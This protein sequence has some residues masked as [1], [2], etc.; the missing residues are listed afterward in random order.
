[1]SEKRWRIEFSRQAKE[2]LSKLRDKK[3]IARI[4]KVISALAINPRP[5][6]SIKLSGEEDMHRVRIGDWR[7]I[8][9]V[10]DDILLVLILEIGQ[11]KDI[12]RRR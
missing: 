3:L 9:S 4:E 8:Y 1:M 7:V 11:R 12:Y 6:G 2:T 5:M 10:E